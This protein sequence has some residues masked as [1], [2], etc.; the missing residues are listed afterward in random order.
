MGDLVAPEGPRPAWW[1]SHTEAAPAG[2]APETVA[3]RRVLNHGGDRDA[4]LRPAY[5]RRGTRSRECVRRRIARRPVDR[6]R[7]GSDG[8]G[9]RRDPR[10]ALRCKHGRRRRVVG[11]GGARNRIGAVVSRGGRPDLAASRLAAVDRADLL[12]VGG[13]DHEVLELNQRPGRPLRCQPA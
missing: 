5:T 9:R 6:G 8:T 11:G 4:A 2:T 3:S 1:C 10:Q 7:F 13:A 12:I